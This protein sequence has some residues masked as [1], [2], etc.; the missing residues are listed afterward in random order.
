MQG[1]G[2]V[3]MK[4]VLAGVLLFVGVGH[5]KAVRTTLVQII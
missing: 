5:F 1:K 3:L 2:R 4:R